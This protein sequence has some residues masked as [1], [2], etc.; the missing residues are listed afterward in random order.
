MNKFLETYRMPKW[1]QKETDNL[2]RLI[3]RSETSSVTFKNSCKQKS[4][5][6]RLH[7]G[8]LPNIKRRTYPSQTIPKIEEQETLLNIF[9]EDTITLI[10]K[11]DKDTTK[12]DNHR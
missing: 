1:S 2:N 8:I 9:Y 11:P 12:K 6:G 5:T 3:T 10:P 7:W 4:R